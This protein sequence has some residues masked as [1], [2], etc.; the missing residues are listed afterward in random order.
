MPECYYIAILLVDGPTSSFTRNL[1]D[2]FLEKAWLLVHTN[3]VHKKS[4]ENDVMH[5][6]KH[7]TVWFSLMVIVLF[8]LGEIHNCTKKA[9]G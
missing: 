9:G 5:S 4:A 2:F 6:R 8:L 3:D 7:S 1:R